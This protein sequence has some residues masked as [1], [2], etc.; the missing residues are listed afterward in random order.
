ML[1]NALG[2]T[3]PAEKLVEPVRVLA[4][5]LYQ[6][7]FPAGTVLLSPSIKSWHAYLILSGKVLVQVVDDPTLK[8]SWGA[9]QL[10]GEIALLTGTERTATVTSLTDVQLL[11]IEPETFE[12]VVER[13]PYLTTS[14]SL[15]ASHRLL[16][17]RFRLAFREI[18]QDMEEAVVDELEALVRLH[19]LERGER[20]S[21]RDGSGDDLYIL[22]SGELMVLKE[23]Q[24]ELTVS[25]RYH[26]G[27]L[28]GE[29]SSLFPLA[30]KASVCA[31]SHSWLGRLTL[32]DVTQV[33][34]RHPDWWFPFMQRCLNTFQ[35]S[36]SHLSASSHTLAL[37]PLTSQA[38]IATFAVELA[39]TL[40]QHGNVQIWD[41]ERLE[42]AGVLWAG[43]SLH[44]QSLNLVRL[45]AWLEARRRDC[46]HVILVLSDESS[47]FAE[48]VLENADQLLWVGAGVVPPSFSEVFSQVPSPEQAKIWEPPSRLVLLHPSEQTLP[49]QT[50]A[51]LDALPK[52]PWHHVRYG[53]K[54]DMARFAR[55]LRGE[56]VGIALSGGAARAIAHLGVVQALQEYGI[57]LDCYVGASAGAIMA[58]LLG[59]DVPIGSMEERLLGAV[60]SFGAMYQSVAL[61][62][63][64]L[65]HNYRIRKALFS[66]FGERT[67]EDL[68]VPVSVMTADLTQSR[69]AIHERGPLVRLLLASSSLPGFLPPV[70][71]Q[72]H[73]HADGGVVENL[74]LSP[75]IQRGC[76]VFLGSLVSLGIRSEAL[77]FSEM[78]SPWKVVWSWITRSQ[79]YRGAEFLILTAMRAVGI[80]SD[81]VHQNNASRLDCLFEPPVESF[82]V[83]DFDQFKALIETGYQ[84]TREQAAS[85]PP[86]LRNLRRRLASE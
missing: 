39:E 58:G 36:T 75:L 12:R 57:E 34:V 77:P 60:Q 66:L 40:R 43:E 53:K 11:R 81:L 29:M 86:S 64:G 62:V 59:E 4:Q 24:H 8:L 2:N 23:T 46:A 16:E 80:A 84:Y 67:L 19:S 7:Q 82:S 6:E 3:L 14:L 51:W 41:R 49:E 56:A 72:G 44:S 48:R 74:P 38:D 13:F 78:P 71:Y 85:L 26:A 30:T 10:V 63:L 79:R 83:A 70:V 76:S 9:G 5:S 28:V 17:T 68:W 54:R 25:K 21:P 45:R 42:E 61:P 65:L 15:L 22:I 32:H 1:T 52:L 55:W 69:P 73:L 27:E 35:V 33:L 20:L 31:A 18:F 47:Q 37:I 50:A